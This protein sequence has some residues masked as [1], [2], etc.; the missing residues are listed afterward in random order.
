M[1]PVGVCWR[2]AGPLAVWML[3]YPEDVPDAPATG[4]GLT[5]GVAEDGAIE[6]H[7]VTVV[8]GAAAVAG[9]ELFAPL[10]DVTGAPI[11]TGAAT[12]TGAPTVT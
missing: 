12:V 8:D 3:T 6:V 9:A 4:G 11:F 10:P 7:V 5:V 1:R 2:Y